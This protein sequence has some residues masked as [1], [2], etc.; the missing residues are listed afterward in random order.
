ML[1]AT[2]VPVVLISLHGYTTVT[3]VMVGCLTP[4]RH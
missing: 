1:G 3:K 2:E 4:N